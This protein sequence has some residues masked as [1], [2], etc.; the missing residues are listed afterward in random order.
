MVHKII[1]ISGSDS[2][3]SSNLRLLHYLKLHCADVFQIQLLS[4]N[5]LPF[6]SA[7]NAEK[8]QAD[9]DYVR[10][11]LHEADGVIIATSE[12]NYSVPANIKNLIDWCSLDPSTL[13]HK[14]IMLL[15]AS[16]G[17]LGTVRAQQHLRQ[18]LTSPGINACITHETECLV[19]N[20]PDKFSTDGQLID[21]ETKKILH[22]LC[23]EFYSLIQN[24]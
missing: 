13:Q 6:L 18:I 9:L 19:G 7:E 5:Q 16:T 24:N 23:A 10:N 4:I 20:A 12:I 11:V 1:A 15:G 14:P 3:L 17:H 8:Y 21:S 2:P 22:N